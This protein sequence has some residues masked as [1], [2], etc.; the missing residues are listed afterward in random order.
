MA[1][2]TQTFLILCISIMFLIHF[3]EWF[4]LTSYYCDDVLSLFLFI[5][6]GTSTTFT[7]SLF[8][9]IGMLDIESVLCDAANFG[10]D[11]RVNIEPVLLIPILVLFTY[12]GSLC[13]GD[14][15]VMTAEIN[16]H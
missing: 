1:C 11:V 16:H 8:F 13:S 3:C 6:K 7:I 12:K 2:E 14:L 9:V 5:N 10:I 4:T 15:C